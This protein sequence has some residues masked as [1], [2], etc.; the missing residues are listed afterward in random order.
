MLPIYINLL[1]NF[2]QAADVESADQ[3]LEDSTRNI[4]LNRL[5]SEADNKIFEYSEKYQAKVGGKDCWSKGC[6]GLTSYRV[7]P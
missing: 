4:I 5:L 2:P 7:L 3:L 6:G 1:R